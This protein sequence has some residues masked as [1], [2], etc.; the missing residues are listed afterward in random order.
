M[1]ERRERGKR[2]GAHLELAH[3]VG[4]HRH[5]HHDE[6]WP[7]DLEVQL[8]RAEKGDGLDRLA[9]THFIGQHARHALGE[10]AQ[11]KV[12]ARDLV[13]PH[14]HSL[15][16]EAGRLLVEGKLLQARGH[17]GQ[18]GVGHGLRQ[19]RLGVALVGAREEDAELIKVARHEAQAGLL[20]QVLAVAQRVEV[21]VRHGVGAL[22]DCD[23]GLRRRSL[24]A[25]LRLG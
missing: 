9:Q 6:V 24:A 19:K 18:V 1:R 17:E 5:G 10:L 16:V 13:V 22:F 21:Q 23:A 7:A 25:I 2:G 12:D 8:E 3:P 11:H 14:A 15:R 20:A 4:Q